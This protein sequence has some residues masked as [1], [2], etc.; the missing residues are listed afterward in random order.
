MRYD[1]SRKVETSQGSHEVTN[2]LSDART[3]QRTDILHKLNSFVGKSGCA[4]HDTWGDGNAQDF[5]SSDEHISDCL[6]KVSSWASVELRDHL[7]KKRNKSSSVFKRLIGAYWVQEWVVLVGKW[8]EAHKAH[9]LNILWYLKPQW[10]SVDEVRGAIC[11][12]EALT[13]FSLGIKRLFLQ[14]RGS[15]SM[16]LE[17]KRGL[18][19][20]FS[21]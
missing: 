5:P 8:S 3:I 21:L 1:E 19:S 4:R 6:Q 2:T 13:P 14:R 20:Y 12:W 16:R 7:I 10:V 9:T 17:P 15:T 11:E 18:L